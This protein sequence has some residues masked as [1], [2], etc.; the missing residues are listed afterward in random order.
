MSQLEK[1]I[2]G[3]SYVCN[4]QGQNIK[5]T[6]QVR[7]GD[8]LQIYVTDGQIKAAVTGTVKPEGERGQSSHKQ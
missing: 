5:K 4:S 3:Y 7:E 2:Q 6:D 1:L 8:L